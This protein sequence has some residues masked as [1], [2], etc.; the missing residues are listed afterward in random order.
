M[1]V[2]N[3]SF[4]SKNISKP[5]RVGILLLGKEIVKY[6]CCKLSTVVTPILNRF[7]CH[8]YQIGYGIK[9]LS[10]WD[11]IGTKFK[12]WFIVNFLVTSISY[13]Y[14][15]FVSEQD[16]RFFSMTFEKKNVLKKLIHF[17]IDHLQHHGNNGVC[18][19]YTLRALLFCL[20]II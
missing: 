1:F 16:L 14:I 6:L 13:L 17:D 3:C 20:L 2:R 4:I 9:W 8:C 12:K 15:W 11:H 5:V 18:I 19:M 10:H 7:I